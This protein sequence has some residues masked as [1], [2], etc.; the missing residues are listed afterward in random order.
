MFE[1]PNPASSTVDVRIMGAPTAT[2]LG[3]TTVGAPIN[4]FIARKVLSLFGEFA[5]PRRT[6]A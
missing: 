5:V 6:T 3:V 1:S 2:G 4:A